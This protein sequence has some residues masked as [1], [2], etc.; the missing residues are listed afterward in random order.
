MEYRWIFS[1]DKDVFFF[2]I[3]IIILFSIIYNIVLI[4]LICIYNLCIFV[5]QKHKDMTTDTTTQ[6]EELVKRG[7]EIAEAKAKAE[8]Q[9]RESQSQFPTQ[10]YTYTVLDLKNYGKFETKFFDAR[11]RK[12]VGSRDW[13]FAYDRVPMRMKEIVEIANGKYKRTRTIKIDLTQRN[14]DSTFLWY[15]IA[16]VN[17]KVS[18]SY[19]RHPF[20]FI[21]QPVDAQQRVL[22]TIL[23][24]T[25]AWNP[26]MP[27]ASKRVF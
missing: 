5:W 22:N 2:K 19:Y 3:I 25:T 20:S 10:T 13:S 17:G 12:A 24:I 7:E 4:I 11:F 1:R 21:T 27:K 15:I 18:A 6:F 9:S 8:S 23:E 26:P 16:F 14:G